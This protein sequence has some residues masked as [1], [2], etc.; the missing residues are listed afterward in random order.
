MSAQAK[1][2]GVFR[3][4]K[5]MSSRAAGA[6]AIRHIDPDLTRVALLYRLV[7]H[8]DQLFVRREAARRISVARAAGLWTAGDTDVRVR[9]SVVSAD[10]RREV[11]VRIYLPVAGIAPHPAVMFMHGGAFISGDLDFE[12]PRCL[13]MCRET[14]LAVVSVDYRLAPEH[15]F[16]AGLEDCLLVYQWLCAEGP[17][18]GLDPTRIAVAGSSAGGTLA[19]AVCLKVRDMGLL[20][21]KLQ[22]LLYPVMDDRLRTPSM[23]AFTDTPAWTYSNCVHMWNHYLG[24]IEQRGVV[25]AHAAPARA[26]DLSGLPATYV[27]TAE[28]DPLR[29]EGA[30]Y[31]QRLTGAGVSTELHQFSGT[32]HGFDTLASA[33]V[34]RRARREHYDV[35]RHA[36]K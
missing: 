35:L 18:S 34:S 10:A 1:L 12:H 11:A 3:T 25:S 6:A 31:A 32:F 27:M 24:P 7:D 13:E 28:Y 16:P 22:M 26:A 36:L 17:S 4:A 2:R 8:G 21:P 14:G 9:D 33:P 20:L 23:L 30:E 29:D 5:T 15:P 19:A